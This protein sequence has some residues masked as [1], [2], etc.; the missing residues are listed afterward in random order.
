MMADIGTSDATDPRPRVVSVDM[1]PSGRLHNYLATPGIELRRGTQV[2]VESEIGTCMATVEVEPHEPCPR[3]DI[4]ELKPILRVADEKDLQI[5]EENRTLE[6]VAR[7]TCAEKISRRGL[8]MKL[9]DVG[10]THDGRKV[11]FYFLSEHRVDFRELVR[12]LANSLHAR[13]EMRQIGAR[14]EAKVC[15]GV[16][17]CG[18]GLCCSSWMRDFDAVTLKMAR[19]QNLALNP[20]RLAGMCGRLKCC[21]RFE[22]ATY[23]DLK[24]GL[25]SVGK[26]VE[27][28]KG[29]GKVVRQNLLKQTVMIERAD[30]GIVAE[31][32]L[33]DLVDKRAQL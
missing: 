7:Q 1:R 27:S 8:D 3:T 26:M 13:I 24:R 16:G 10:Y 23:V 4:S 28:V 14:D 17:P 9:V 12:D 29:D 11:I 31:A 18:R 2:L 19:E 6:A 25:P 32:T 15:C 33:E 21:L 30:D 20:S 22:F 5:E